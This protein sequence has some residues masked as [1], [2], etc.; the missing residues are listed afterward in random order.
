MAGNVQKTN[1]KQQ[2]VIES[3]F[4][5]VN[6]MIEDI[7]ETSREVGDLGRECG[8]LPGDRRFH[9]RIEFDCCETDAE[10]TGPE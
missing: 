4:D 2:A 7:H 5:S 6:M 3:T 9:G 1:E 8:K 10:C